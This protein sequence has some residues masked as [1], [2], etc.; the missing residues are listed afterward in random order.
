MNPLPIVYTTQ[1][2][3]I[4]KHYARALGLAYTPVPAPWLQGV[5]RLVDGQWRGITPALWP[6][7]ATDACVEVPIND[8]W[9]A[10][11]FL[12]EQDGRPVIGELRIFPTEVPAEPLRGRPPGTWSGH[13]LGMKA[14][15]PRGGLS[16]RL[17]RGVKVGYY[18]KA[19]LRGRRAAALPSGLRVFHRPRHPTASPRSEAS[20]RG[21]PPRPDEELIPIAAAYAD[22][23]RRG[24][25]HP[26]AALVKQLK[27]SG[28][29]IRD[30]IHRA[31]QRGLLTDAR[32]GVP[33]GEL[34]VRGR[35]LLAKVSAR[36]GKRT[37]AG[38]PRK[39][40][41]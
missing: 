25:D 24:E 32:P 19:E 15:V 17:L 33:G 35:A 4:P 28:A 20:R 13:A 34:T 26:R 21:R 27:L 11:Y 3:S 30:R 29:T 6:V 39:V 1:V 5:G 41:R 2:R 38:V 7:S 12:V 37:R 22:A 9:T 36:R 8:R 23:V 40:A 31:R 14:P 18:F 10:A 16:A